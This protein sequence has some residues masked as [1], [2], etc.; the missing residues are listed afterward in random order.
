MNLSHHIILAKAQNATYKSAMSLEYFVVMLYRRLMLRTETV[1]VDSNSVMLRLKLLAYLWRLSRAC[2]RI[3][4]SGRSLVIGIL[5]NF[6]QS[7]NLSLFEP[8][9]ALNVKDF[10]LITFNLVM[11][12]VKCASI[13]DDCKRAEFVSYFAIAFELFLMFQCNFVSTISLKTFNLDK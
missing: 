5:D 2:T 1:W 8:L 4:N 13:C 11:N 12:A 10:P 6:I 9:F 7:R 3:S